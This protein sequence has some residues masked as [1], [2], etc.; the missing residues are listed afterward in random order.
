MAMFN[1]YAWAVAGT[2]H[3]LS[4]IGN[5]RVEPAVMVG[6]PKAPVNPLPTVRVSAILQGVTG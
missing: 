3:E 6:G 1:E 4:G 2:L 5:A